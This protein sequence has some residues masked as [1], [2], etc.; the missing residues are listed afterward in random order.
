MSLGDDALSLHVHNTL[1][2]S[3]REEWLAVIVASLGSS[4]AAFGTLPLD[5]RAEFV[6]QELLGSDLSHAALP[7]VPDEVLQRD[8]C[9][10]LH[11]R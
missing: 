6:L 4:V 5:R 7:R 3:V 9:G 2:I 8:F 10:F 11:G 1:G